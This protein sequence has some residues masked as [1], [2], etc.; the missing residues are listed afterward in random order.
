MLLRIPEDEPLRRAQALFETHREQQLR[1]HF[2]HNSVVNPTQYEWID[3]WTDPPCIL[4]GLYILLPF[5]KTLGTW[6]FES[7]INITLADIAKTSLDQLLY[8]HLSATTT[9]SNY[10]ADS[11]LLWTKEEYFWFIDIAPKESELTECI[12][13]GEHI[14][15]LKSFHLYYTQ[16]EVSFQ[17]IRLLSHTEGGYHLVITEGK[18]LTCRWST[19][20]WTTTLENPDHN[21]VNPQVYHFPP[22]TPTNPE[23]LEILEFCAARNQ[24]I[25]SFSPLPPSSPDKSVGSWGEPNPAWGLSSCCATRKFVTAVIAVQIHHLHHLV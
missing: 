17:E 20:G 15:Y 1:C 24:P 4:R 19:P 13:A 10:P 14:R 12:L 16:I 3:C 23:V 8:W 5:A 11:I 18:E 9:I 25:P 2:P 6:D 21:L 7:F 22:E